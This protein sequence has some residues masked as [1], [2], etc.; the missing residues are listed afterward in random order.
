MS[1]IKSTAKQFWK[2]RF[3]R[4]L[5]LFMILVGIFAFYAVK[6]PS[7][8]SENGLVIHFFYTPT[9]PYCRDQKPVMEEL[10]AELPDITFHHLDASS[11]AGSQ[12]FYQLST[13]AG[14][15]PSRIGVPTIFIGKHPLVGLH[16]KEQIIQ[17]IDECREQCL[18]DGADI[19]VQ[20]METS[21]DDF[22]LPFI[23]R[24][25]LTKYS[26]PVLAI[27]LGLID[28]FNPCAM[29]VLVFLIGLLLG[30]KSRKKIFIVLGS[31]VF[32]SAVSYFLFMTAWLNLFLLIGYIRIITLLIGIFAL[33]AG[34]A[35]LKEFFTSK[36]GLTCK[37]GDE[38]SHEKTM[39]K[40]KSILSRPLSVGVFFSI[41]GLAFAVNAIEFVC[42]AAIPAIYTQLL[43]LS[44]ISTFHHYLYIL[45]YVFFYMLDHI[46]I[47]TMVAFALGLG[48]GEKYARYCK[49]IGGIILAVL[50]IVMVF[51]PH[52]LR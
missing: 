22:E 19:P 50:G 37:V 14:M 32:A 29:W 45:I 33:G 26:L 3:N 24:T 30:E 11:T 41:I 8:T 36:E 49:L 28:G 20:E 4:Y 7:V 47:F 23:G 46:I 15:D 52:L 18:M 48:I 35:H 1:V 39:G 10:E 16:T 25:D 34:I 43:A 13:E 12:L 42:S 6:E 27:I 21:F 9:C 44:G 2:S 5:V 40:I 51:A 31:F 38:E 17:A